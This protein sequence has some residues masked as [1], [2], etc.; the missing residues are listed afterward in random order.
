MQFIFNKIDLIIIYETI[1]YKY[2]YLITLI[3]Y[4]SSQ[5]QD[6]HS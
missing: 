5:T 1:F 6:S 2:M 3:L 4:L